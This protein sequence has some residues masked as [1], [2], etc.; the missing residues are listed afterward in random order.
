M[1]IRIGFLS[2]GRLTEVLNEIRDDY[3]DDVE[4]YIED[5]PKESVVNIAK[6]MKEK[7]SVDVFISAGANGYTLKKACITPYVEIN[8]SITDFLFAIKQKGSSLGKVGIITYKEM[9]PYIQELK[10][11]INAEIVERTY[12]KVYQ[13][14]SIIDELI[15]EN[16]KFIIGGSLVVEGANNKNATG[17]FLYSRSSVKIAIDEAI[18]LVRLSREKDHLNKRLSAMMEFTYEGIITTDHN[19]VIEIF[20]KSA[21]R[22]TGIPAEKAIGKNIIDILPN[23]RL[24]KVISTKIVETNQ[25]QNIGSQEIITN[26]IPVIVNNE[27]YG[28]IATFQTVNT[29]QE[30][31]EKIRRKQLSK[32]FTAN[33]YFKDIIGES[34]K[35]KKVKNE[36]KK[37]SK[38]DS[39]ILLLG[40]SGTGKDVFAQSIHNH[41]PRRNKP[42]VAINC[43]S[44]PDNL[45]ES[46][47]FGYDEGAFT[48]SKKGGKKGMFELA[49]GGTIF[50]DEIG[51]VTLAMQARLLRIIENREVMRIGGQSIIP[52]DI[53]IIAATNKNTWQLVQE[54]KF[55]EDFYYRICVL[56][57]EIPPLRERK[58]DIPLFIKHYFREIGSDI[59]ESKVEEISNHKILINNRWRGNIRE[60][61]NIIERIAAIYYEG[62]D[63]E[64][65]I[66]DSI[67]RNNI[68]TRENM[69]YLKVLNECGGN[70]TKASEKLGISRTT[71]WRRLKAD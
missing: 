32:G 13:I 25:T 19:S 54:G 14:E 21:E 2:Y 65:L 7:H 41:S 24:D 28:A 45:L 70:M 48:G 57:A 8:P 37:F 71:L 46:E 11:L 22:I 61:K 16:V 10:D 53:R 18:K 27:V 39:T 62:A 17:I 23:T 67:G 58:N 35:I 60:L 15:R 63:I 12:E 36:L 4:F 42:Y 9:L 31:E 44:L 56:E 40:E 30:T 43:S 69:K 33:M 47:L 38:S 29:L 49:H 1:K 5:T 66:S 59:S 50:L 3:D 6:K 55:R 64:E 52:V 20:N 68:E 51:D 34:E 26:R